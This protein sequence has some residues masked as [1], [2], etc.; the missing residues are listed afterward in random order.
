MGFWSGL[1]QK[2]IAF[3]D[4]GDKKIVFRTA[5]D[6]EAAYNMIIRKLDQVDG[7]T[8]KH[9][10]KSTDIYDGELCRGSRVA[11]ILVLL[12]KQRTPKIILY[13]NYYEDVLVSR[14]ISPQFQTRIQKIVQDITDEFSAKAE[15][16]IGI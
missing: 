6:A 1:A 11:A 8:T 9:R 15:I 12:S 5:E 3:L 7:I 4:A 10:K 2:V 13:Y 16:Y 14:K